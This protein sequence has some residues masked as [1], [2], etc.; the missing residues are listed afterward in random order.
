MNALT[1]ARIAERFVVFNCEGDRCIGVVTEPVNVPSVGDIGVVVVVGGPQYRAGSH[2]QFRLLARELATAGIPVLRF[3]YRGLGDSEGEARSFESI[4]TDLRAAIDTML[5]QTPT[6]RIVL[7]GLC[8]GASAGLMYAGSDSRVA[9][10]V[11]VNPWARSPQNEASTLL[12]HYYR[13]RFFSLAFWRKVL[14]GRF[15]LQDS[16]NDLVSAVRAGAG[17]EEPVGATAY[18]ARMQ[19]G[20]V[21]FRGPVLFVLSE[22]DFTARE[23]EEWIG[24][25]KERSRMFR[26]ERCRV[27]A[28]ANADHTFSTRAWRDAA[29]RKT[30]EWITALADNR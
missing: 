6:R 21:R 27:C 28:V 5:A 10:V 15:S 18:L 20:W 4:D 14:S 22:N 26:G 19:Q 9:G 30:I 1:D 3:D 7:W 13:R 16:K 11:A 2:R 29:A 12:K 17:D 23:F 24:R 8:D 25:D